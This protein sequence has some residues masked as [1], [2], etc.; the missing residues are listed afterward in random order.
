MEKIQN[1]NIMAKSM[2]NEKVNRELKM[3][4]YLLITTLLLLSVSCNINRSSKAEKYKA[5][6][7]RFCREEY[8]INPSVVDE[9]A[10]E[11]IVVSYPAYKR[12]FGTSNIRGREAVKNLSAGFC[13][14]WKETQITFHE[15]IAEGNS[16][17]LVWTFKGRN[18]GSPL[19]DVKPTNKIETWG[20]ITIYRFNKDG[21]IKTEYGLESDPGP[22]ERMQIDDSF[23]GN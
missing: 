4:K 13:N 20:G 8:G 21:R 11:D 18:A 22:I 6:A 14:R 12:F 10:A 19:P 2:S 1:T 3:Y 17:V 5:L 7:E 15:S 23:Q 9:L 16:V